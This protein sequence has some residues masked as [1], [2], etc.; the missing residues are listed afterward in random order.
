MEERRE[1]EELGWRL[2][3]GGVRSEEEMTCGVLKDASEMR[4]EGTLNLDP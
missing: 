4:F 1:E 3:K 2:T